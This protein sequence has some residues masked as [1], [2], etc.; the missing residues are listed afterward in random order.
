MP[1]EA[2][3]LTNINLQKVLKWQKAHR[4]SYRGK[5]S[6]LTSSKSHS[7]DLLHQLI[8]KPYIVTL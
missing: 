7:P 2:E 4:D 1:A 5:I 6:G 3:N 8:T